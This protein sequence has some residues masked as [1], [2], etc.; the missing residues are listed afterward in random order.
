MKT[1]NDR[2]SDDSQSW[3]QGRLN[4]TLGVCKYS[5]G[6]TSDS[7]QDTSKPVKET[8]NVPFKFTGQIE[9]VV[10]NLGQTKLGATDQQK[11]L[12]AEAKLA[13]D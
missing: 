1:R 12:V 11:L 6:E 5:A 8:Y 9:R 4:T 10:I 13:A 7:G 2:R 3:R